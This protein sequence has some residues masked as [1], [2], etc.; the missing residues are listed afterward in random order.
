MASPC[1]RACFLLRSLVLI[2]AVSGFDK[3]YE[4]PNSFALKD[5][6]QEQAERKILPKIDAER[7]L[8]DDFARSSPA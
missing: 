8:A 4:A 6:S 7:L 5:K 3:M 1:R 2:F